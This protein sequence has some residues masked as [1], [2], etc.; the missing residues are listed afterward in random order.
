M[1]SIK[2]LRKLVTLGAIVLALIHLFFPSLSIDATTLGLL[3]IALIPWLAPL[4]KSL[5]LPGGLKV[6]LQDVQEIADKAEEAGLLASGTRQQE[7]EHSFQLIEKRD[8]NLALAGLRI[9]IERRLVAIGEKHDLQGPFRGVSHLLRALDR[10]QVLTHEQRSVLSDL[11]GL[12]N[13]AVHGATVD[14]QAAAWA[15]E[16]GPDILESLDR[17]LQPR[18]PRVSVQQDEPKFPLGGDIWIPKD[19]G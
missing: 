17:L 2:R 1:N 14:P 6:E 4:V 13:S 19:E 15:M 5:E 8:A 7:P 10:K 3:V 12:L 16:T 11:I 18:T 9:E